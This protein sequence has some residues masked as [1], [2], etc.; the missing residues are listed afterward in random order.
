MVRI[1]DRIVSRYYATPRQ[2]D[3]VV[4]TESG[5]YY[6][7]D[8]RGNLICVDSPTACIQEAVDALTPNRSWIETVLIRSGNYIINDTIM[9]D[10][11]T[12]LVAHDAYLKLGNGVNKAM[13]TNRNQINGNTYIII[14]GGTYDGNYQENPSIPTALINF[15]KGSIIT[16]TDTTIKNTYNFALKYN[17][18]TLRAFRN[19]FL[20]N[21]AGVNLGGADHL[22]MHNYY[23]NNWS[24]DLLLSSG[25][26]SFLGDYFGSNAANNVMVIEN[27]TYNKFVGCVFSDASRENILMRVNNT[28]LPVPRFNLFVGNLI[29]QW[30]NKK[31]NNTY[32]MVKIS[33]GTYNAFIG[34][35]IASYPSTNIPMYILEELST[36]GPNYFIDNTLVG[37][38]GTAPVNLSG[39]NSVYKF[40]GLILS[41]NSGVAVL[42]VGS[43]RVTVNHN[44]G[45][46][47]NKILLTPGANIRVWYENV[48]NTSFDIVTDTAPTSDVYISWRAEL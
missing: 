45:I 22:F 21:Y 44:M 41:E 5:H 33:Y 17:G 34:N 36:A 39:V 20:N 35:M 28:S 27:A 12:R 11:F 4:Y 46:K 3:V 1:K 31:D 14:E 32:S 9:L 15:V 38:Y 7:K 18:G 8:R 16:I 43:T 6:A 42:S 19:W 37:K 47:P 2:Y 29:A 23:S 40:R 10:S 48:T 26:S 25:A 30:L 24:V 13:I